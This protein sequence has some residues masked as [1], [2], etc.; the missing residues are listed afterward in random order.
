MATN[1]Y[2]NAL[3][4]RSA[5]S[6]SSGSK[7]VSSL[8]LIALNPFVGGWG[9]MLLIGILVATFPILGG[10]TISYWTATAVYSLWYFFVRVNKIR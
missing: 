9:L 3:S 1:T 8:L 7:A 2:Y 5:V 10:V 6:E 4:A